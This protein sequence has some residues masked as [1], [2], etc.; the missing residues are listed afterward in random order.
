M[1]VHPTIFKLL[2]PLA[3]RYGACGFRVPRD[4]IWLALGYNRQRV[5]I[6]L[7]WAIIFGLLCRNYP[8]RL[9]E[10]RLAITHRMYGLMQTGLMQEA[11]VVRVLQHLDIPTAELYF[12][13][14]TQPVDEPLGPNPGDLATLLSPAVREVIQDRGLHLAT[15]PTLV[16]A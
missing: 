11:Y 14:N 7:V 4:D 16:E 15:Y 3:E 5:G 9:K 10:H 13:P 8:R 6:K 1:H 12:H 2:L